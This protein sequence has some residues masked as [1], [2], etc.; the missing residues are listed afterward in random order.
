MI[1]QSRLKKTLKYNP[2]TGD[3][4]W[5]LDVSFGSVAG[6][7]NGQGYRVIRINNRVYL[8]HRLVFLY[9]CGSFPAEQVDHINGVRDDN[10]R[11][12]LRCV[13]HKTNGRNQ[14]MKINN[15]SGFTGVRRFGNRWRARIS[16]HGKEKH[17]GAF[18]NKSDAIAARK[19]AEA[20]YGYH[21]NH[22]RK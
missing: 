17:L 14:R 20:K 16:A 4:T 6:G 18:A 10:R 21:P 11:C 8:S 9:L 12:N 1:T 13:D 19:I 3:F 22:G 15:T 2:N 7:L 5:L